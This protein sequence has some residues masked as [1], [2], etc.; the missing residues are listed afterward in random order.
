VVSVRRAPLPF[1]IGAVP[2][3]PS[4]E[5]HQARRRSRRPR[6]PRSPVPVRLASGDE[7]RGD[8]PQRLAIIAEG[9]AIA[10]T[11][12][13]EPTTFVEIEE[14]ASIAADDAGV[15]DTQSV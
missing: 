4:G 11:G 13:I 5:P 3:A 6:G 15:G 8:H 9:Q 12:P 1:I 14:I 2:R 7:H 10:V